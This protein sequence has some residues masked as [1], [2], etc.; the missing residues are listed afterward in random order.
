MVQARQGLL[1]VFAQRRQLPQ[2]EV[3][4]MEAVHQSQALGIAVKHQQ[5]LAK[6]CPLGLG[7]WS[8]ARAKRPSSSWASH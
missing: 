7:N 8:W 1:R 6:G 4:L 5:I 2:G 3:Q